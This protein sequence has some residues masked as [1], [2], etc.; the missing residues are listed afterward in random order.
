MR[1]ANSAELAARLGDRLEHLAEDVEPGLA[2]LLE[3]LGEDLEGDARD[4]DV[5]LEGGDALVGAGDLE[6]HVAEV[7]FDAGDVGEDDVVVAS[8]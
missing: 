4:L 7:V 5:H 8:P 2:G 1:G 3:R 6:V